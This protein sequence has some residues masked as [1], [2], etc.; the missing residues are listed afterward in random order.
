[1]HRFL[2]CTVCFSLLVDGDV[3]TELVSTL[4]FSDVALKTKPPRAD[5]SICVRGSDLF[6]PG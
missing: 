4:K 5:F 2:F 1:M 3:P 6:E